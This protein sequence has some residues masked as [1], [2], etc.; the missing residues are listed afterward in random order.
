M[1]VLSQTKI[2]NCFQLS[3]LYGTR[4][5]WVK[6][7]L[8][9]SS[10]GMSEATEFY[11]AKTWDLLLSQNLIPHFLFLPMYIPPFH[12]TLAKL[13][14]HAGFIYWSLG[15][16][17]LIGL[18]SVGSIRI[19][20]RNMALYGIAKRNHAGKEKPAQFVQ[21]LQQVNKS[22][23]A[24]SLPGCN[25]SWS[26]QP[27][28]VHVSVTCHFSPD[29]S[30][31]QFG[32]LPEGVRKSMQRAQIHGND[33]NT[34]FAADEIVLIAFYTYLL[35]SLADSRFP[36]LDK[37][38]KNNRP[39]QREAKRHN[40]TDNHRD[41]KKAARDDKIKTIH[42]RPTNTDGE[43]WFTLHMNSLCPSRTYWP[44]SLSAHSL[45]LNIHPREV[46]FRHGFYYSVVK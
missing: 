20:F 35:S 37:D 34:G 32:T 26:G 18:I 44:H 3:R 41:T 11:L 29:N 42:L 46:S 2:P 28:W 7:F 40:S 8:T 24:V 31:V 4:L 36:S 25:P 21:L 45:S 6:M 1:L 9:L 17:D 14:S 30:Q 13:K 16:I 5:D 23:S 39:E 43:S 33:L 38:G 22:I 10:A 12:N 19:D 15:K 27:S